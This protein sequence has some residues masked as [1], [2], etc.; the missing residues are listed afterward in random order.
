M[1]IGCVRIGWGEIFNVTGV[2]FLGFGSPEDIMD[3]GDLFQSSVYVIL[4]LNLA[5]VQTFISSGN[6]GF[7]YFIIELVAEVPI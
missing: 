1:T 7:Q 3:P 6:C 2:K 5:V 4:S